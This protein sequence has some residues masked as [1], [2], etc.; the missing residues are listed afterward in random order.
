MNLVRICD[1]NLHKAK[2]LNEIIEAMARQDLGKQK[3]QC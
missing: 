2:D 1:S 3:T